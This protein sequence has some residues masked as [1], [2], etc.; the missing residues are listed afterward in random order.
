[1]QGQRR[2]ASV[3]LAGVAVV[4]HLLVNFAHGAAHNALR[5]DAPPGSLPFVVIVIFI[6][7]VVGFA[8]LLRNRRAGVLVVAVASLVFGVAYHFVID[9]PDRYDHVGSGAWASTFLTTA[10]LLAIIEIVAIG[11][12]V[13]L[14]RN[15]VD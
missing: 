5:I 9:S 4:V 3:Y 1:M 12:V 8:I 11:A 13:T 6:L 7:P 2:R 14:P 15:S 10:V